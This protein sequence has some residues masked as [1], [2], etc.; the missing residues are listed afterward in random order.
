MLCLLCHKH[1]EV[2]YSHL[3]R[4]SLNVCVLCWFEGNGFDQLGV[5]IDDTTTA[6]FFR[7]AEFSLKVRKKTQVGEM[8]CAL[9][10]SSVYKAH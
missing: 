10:T 2:E 3:L 6:N 8:Y 7:L 4:L 5:S 9:V 1:A